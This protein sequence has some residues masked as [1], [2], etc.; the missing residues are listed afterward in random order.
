[1]VELDDFTTYLKRRSRPNTIAAYLAALGHWVSWLG[2][3]EPSQDTAQEFIDYIEEEGRSNNTIIL[4]ANAIRRY[5]KWKGVPITLDCPSVNI[6]EPHYLTTDQVYQVLNSCR[7][8]LE[9][10]LVTCLFDT[11]CRVSEILNLTT[12]D[13]NW[14]A[15]L[16]T[17]IRKGG[18]QAQVNISD[19]G[20]E[21]LKEWLKV[22][23]SG[24]KR[25]FMDYTYQDVSPVIK[26]LSK[27]SGVLFR[28]HV[29]R[30]SRAV[31]LLESGVDIH[32]VQQALGHRNIGTT[33]NIYGQIS[34]LDLKKH[35]TQW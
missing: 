16:I 30:H 20:L 23:Q 9:K 22:R 11:A 13:I 10:V 34:P 28:A 17:V 8:P 35:I 21:A 24:S 31:Q 14:E 5:F 33:L 12:D 32:F 18:R 15:G 2:N 26:D 19:K 27:R 1:M 3:R 25:V 29:L 7:T 4:T 6:G